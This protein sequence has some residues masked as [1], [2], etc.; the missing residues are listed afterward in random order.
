MNDKDLS[1]LT[2]EQVM[3]LDIGCP[4]SL[5]GRK[6]YE[7]FLQSEVVDKGKINCFPANEKFRFGPSKL[8]E[9]HQRIELTMNLKGAAFK[10]KFFYSGR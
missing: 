3:I 6:E 4:R 7:R 10:A 5:M 9:S 2:N 1:D 8:F